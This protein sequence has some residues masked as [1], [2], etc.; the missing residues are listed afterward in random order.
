MVYV[1][2][3]FFLFFGCARK[4]EPVFR[5]GTNIWPGY[6]LL[7]LAEKL[8]YYEGSKIKLVQLPSASE[9]IRAFRNNTLECA[10]LT[11]DEA[12]LLKEHGHDIRVFLVTN[13][14]NGAD[15]IIA[16][17]DIKEFRELKG[18]K[19]GVE[20]SAL[21][22]LFIAR[23]L[24]LNQMSVDDIEIVPLEVF[25]HEKGFKD[26]IVDAAVT[27]EPV[28][29][30]LLKEGARVVFDSTQIPNEIIDILIVRVSDISKP[31][32]ALE[33]LVDGWFKA[34]GY[35]KANPG[36]ASELMAPRI[37]LKPDEFLKAVN[38]L[39][40]PDIDY[41]IDLLSGNNPSFNKALSELPAFMVSKKLLKEYI[42]PKSIINNMLVKQASK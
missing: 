12:L 38:G 42:D 8:G 34:Y 27:F 13:I 16:R 30:G 5:V 23:A 9:V 18:K 35:F 36:E 19:V 31:P 33:I 39:I 41:N 37:G 20:A 15:V 21:G 26:G 6:E 17:Q 4:T 10:A 28:R 25:E 29:T 14:S 24:E 11:M 40:I 3:L 2:V 32:K 7:Y 22:G 1:L